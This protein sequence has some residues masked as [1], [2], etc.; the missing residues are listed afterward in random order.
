MINEDVVSAYNS[1]LTVDLSQISK[2]TTSQQDQVRHYG[3]LAENLLKNKD[4]AMFVHHFK[5]SLA[6]ELANI[7][8]HQP[9]DNARRIAIGNELA[10]I[11]NFVSSLK[12]AVYYKTRLG[13]TNEVPDGN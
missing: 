13:N 1:R 3:S 11:D 8:G 10:G 2:L 6:D 12:R 5:F 4:L 7:R 9:D